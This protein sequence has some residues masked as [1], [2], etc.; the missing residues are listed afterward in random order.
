MS[1]P[2]LLLTRPYISPSFT[3][4]EIKMSEYLSK[5]R[6]IIPTNVALCLLFIADE[7]LYLSLIYC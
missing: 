2:Y 3:A 1:L 4:G 7:E 5:Y 6:I